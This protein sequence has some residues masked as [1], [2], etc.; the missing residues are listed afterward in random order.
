LAPHVTRQER[1]RAWVPL[2]A[3]G[4]SAYSAVFA[5]VVL[6]PWHQELDDALRNLEHAVSQQR[7]VVDSKRVTL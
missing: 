1:W 2:A 7:A 5:T 3:L 6:Y 4:L